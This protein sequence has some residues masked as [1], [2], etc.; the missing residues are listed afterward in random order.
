MQC[1]VDTVGPA[2]SYKD[3]L[4]GEFPALSFTVCSKA[5]SIYPIVSAA[6][7]AAKVTRDKVMESWTF[8]EEGYEKL[9]GEEA[10]NFGSGYPS[11]Q[12]S[13]SSRDGVTC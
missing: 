13:P 1:F 4:Q 12:S 8:L 9:T 11:G 5:D 3:K 7:I 10:R 6:S 2:D